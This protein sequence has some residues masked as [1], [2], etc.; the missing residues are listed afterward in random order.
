MTMGILAVS[1]ESGLGFGAEE[2]PTGPRSERVVA[3][4]GFWGNRAARPREESRGAPNESDAPASLP[5]APRR[6]AAASNAMRRVLDLLE[7]LARA[8]V[9]VMLIGET[10]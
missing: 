10:G 3:E 7:P 9:T 8:E 5:K 1:A 6:V 4:S 2:L